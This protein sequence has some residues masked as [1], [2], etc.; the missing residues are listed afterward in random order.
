MARGER[1]SGEILMRSSLAVAL[2][3][4]DHVALPGGALR[5]PQLARAVVARA[6]A[7]PLPASRREATKLAVLV[8]VVAQPVDA[9]V[10]ADD[11]VVDVDHD[12]LIVFVDGVLR[13]PVR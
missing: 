7:A 10:L 3:R 2:E 1:A 6:Q 4:E 11:L 12:D 8:H 9:G 13:D 5:R